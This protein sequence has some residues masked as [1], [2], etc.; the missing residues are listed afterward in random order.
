MSSLLQ[1]L[2]LSLAGILVTFAALGLLILVII[3]LR[4]LF[5]VAPEES[6]PQ[7]AGPE[8][9]A[10]SLTERDQARRQAAGVAVAVALLKSGQQPDES[11]GQALETPKGRWW[12][13]ARFKE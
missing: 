12:Y 6:E 3:L 11:L 5:T 7:P 9:P 13:E 10:A 1:G 4:E 2:S 8:G